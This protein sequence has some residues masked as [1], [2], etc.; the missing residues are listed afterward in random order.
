MG[1]L[2]THRPANYE[3]NQKIL[4]NWEIMGIKLVGRLLREIRDYFPASRKA[5][6]AD[7]VIQFCDIREK[8]L[9]ENYRIGYSDEELRLAEASKVRNGGVR[10]RIGTEVK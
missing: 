1:S 6:T 8:R 10:R 7:L 2:S 4:Y 5:E 3:K 9:N